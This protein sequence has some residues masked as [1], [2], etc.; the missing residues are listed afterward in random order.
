VVAPVPRP[1]WG[2][3]LL[4]IFFTGLLAVAAFL[5]L[6]GWWGPLLWQPFQWLLQARH[7][8][9]QAALLLGVT[10]FGVVGYWIM[11]LRL[12]YNVRIHPDFVTCRA[13]D[14]RRLDRKELVR[15]TKAFE[16]LG[17]VRAVDYTPVRPGRRRH[18]GFAR[19]M[20]HPAEG[21]FAEINQI[22]TAEGQPVP[23]RCMVLTLFEDGWSLSATNRRQLGAGWMMRRPRSLWT[24]NPDGTPAQLL[25]GHLKRRERMAADLGVERRTDLSPE[26]FFD[27]VRNGLAGMRRVLWRKNLFVGMIEARLYDASP[28]HEWLGD[29]ARLAGAKARH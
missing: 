20:V 18:S 11:K 2:L 25:A 27:H 10:L 28:R 12:I 24:S 5:F 19:L 29:Y 13:D 8:P 14:F 21:C 15:C 1:A 6:S 16:A 4:A 3:R 23:M 22:F 26:A 17:F 7:V 9:P